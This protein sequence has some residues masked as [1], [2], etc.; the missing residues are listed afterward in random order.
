[1]K[2]NVYSYS[3]TRLT[4]PEEVEE[5]VNIW[6]EGSKAAHHFIDFTYWLKHADAMRTTYIPQS[7]TWVFRDHTNEIAGFVSLVEDYL[8]SLFVHPQKQGRGI[9]SKLMDKVKELKSELSLA[10]YAKNQKAV[11]FYKKSGFDIKETR[12]DPN[13]GE[14]E[15]L[16]VWKCSE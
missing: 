7:D 10:V 13:T 3:I 12:T 5:V 4:D 15:I 6:L 14:E 2:I 16:M 11:S 8:A 9:G 1:M